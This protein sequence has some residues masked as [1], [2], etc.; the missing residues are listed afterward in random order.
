MACCNGLNAGKLRN[1][2]HIQRFVG[3]KTVAGGWSGEWENILTL[4]AYIKPL[5]G[6]ERFFAKRMESVITH[7]IYIRYQN[8]ISA[9]DR[10]EYF[11]RIF[12]I[13]AVL[14]M[15]E[16]NMWLEMPCEEGSGD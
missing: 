10:I 16:K 11:G 5:S 4:K 2:I 3:E 6:S 15:E 13:K 8:V 7:K 1:T 9:A 12:S 14:N